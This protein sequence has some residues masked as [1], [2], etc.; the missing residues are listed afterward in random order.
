MPIPENATATETY[1]MLHKAWARVLARINLDN[2]ELREGLT[3]LVD[4]IPP[5]AGKPVARDPIFAAVER[6]NAALDAE[7]AE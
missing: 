7:S 1:L 6:I 4:A 2:R 5:P 3:D